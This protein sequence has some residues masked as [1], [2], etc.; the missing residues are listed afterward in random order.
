[1]RNLCRLDLI[2][3]T[4]LHPMGADLQYPVAPDAGKL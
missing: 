4:G 2:P 1:M 3:Q